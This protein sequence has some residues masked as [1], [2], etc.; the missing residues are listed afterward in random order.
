MD[1]VV[2]PERRTEGCGVTGLRNKRIVQVT[3]LWDNS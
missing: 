3:G 2:E 1:G